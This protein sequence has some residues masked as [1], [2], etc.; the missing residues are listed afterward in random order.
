MGKPTKALLLLLFKQLHSI[1]AHSV[2]I[3]FHLS[4]RNM[5]TD[6]QNLCLLHEKSETKS[7]K[8]KN[9]N[10]KPKLAE[11]KDSTM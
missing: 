9:N 5:L 4:R 8:E 6:G 1:H 7:G 10:K 3:L 11:Q 2:C